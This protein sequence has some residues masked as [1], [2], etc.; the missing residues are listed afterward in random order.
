MDTYLDTLTEPDALRVF[1]YLREKFGWAGTIFTAEDIANRWI[2]KGN[3][4]LSDS[5]ITKVMDT[6]YWRRGM[7]ETL[8]ETGW[9]VLELAIEE[10]KA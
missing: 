8:C 5:D 6:R 7:S 9:E 2:D 10:V 3:E 4:P 1:Q